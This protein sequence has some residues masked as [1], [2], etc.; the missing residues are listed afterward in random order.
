MAELDPVY[1]IGGSDRPKVD[2]AIERLRRHFEGGSVDRYDAATNDA[3]TEVAACNAGTLFGDQRLVLVDQVDGRGGDDG[4]LRT[5]WKAAD[6]EQVVEYL[7]APAPGTVLA[8][9]ATEV[10]KDAPLVKAVAKAG[11][12]LAFEI[13]KR[14]VTAWVIN[15]FREEGARIDPEA[16][17][18]LVD[19]VGDRDTLALDAEIRKVAT[20]ARSD[21]DAVIGERDVLE[22]A[23]PWG[24]SPP[25]ELT[26]AWADHDVGK[27]LRVVERVLHRAGTPQRR[28]DEAA[29]LSATLGSHLGKL[30]RVSV[31]AAA[32]ERPREHAER[33]KQRAF[34]V[35]KLFR[36]VEGMS[37]VELDDAT[38][39]V[40][41][42]D[43]ALKGGSR[44]PSDLELQLAVT[45]LAADRGRHG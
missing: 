6:V 45:A 14:K 22:L 31:A 5:T 30:R 37:D 11:T 32:G 41:R 40:A 35:E 39:A 24:E 33:T 36:Q 9:V 23:A 3:A 18:L 34:P 27:A 20:W 25:W 12:V 44:L 16:A 21:A 26:D 38:L 1:L 13:E 28:R 2:R 7:R 17:K 29:R 19:L 15:R 8:L 4:R 42:L 43:H 10:K